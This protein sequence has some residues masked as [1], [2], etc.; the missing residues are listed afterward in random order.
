MIKMQSN[1]R[2]VLNTIQVD[3]R[4][5]KDILGNN[6]VSVF[7]DFN[8]DMIIFDSGRI[9]TETILNYRNLLNED[10]SLHIKIEPYWP[11]IN[12]ISLSDNVVEISDYQ[13]TS[14]S[15]EEGM[16]ILIMESDRLLTTN[17]KIYDLMN[18]CDTDIIFPYRPY[19]ISYHITN[20]PINL[21]NRIQFREL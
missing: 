20:D 15:D 13:F 2:L 14:N 19:R 17:G 16:V 5:I 6:I 8:N 4:G 7:F 11:V 9:I 1:S 18:D 21:N 10:C 12:N 3:E